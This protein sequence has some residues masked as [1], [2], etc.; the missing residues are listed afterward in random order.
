MC[1]KIAIIIIFL[2]ISV[3]YS[4]AEVTREDIEK[5]I[6][7]GNLKHPYLFFT[8]EDKPA[9]LERIQNDPVSSDI[10]NRLLAEA[11][12][13]LYTPVES[14]LPR[15]LKNPRYDWSGKFLEY[16]RGYFKAAFQLAFV[17][18]MT[19]DEKYA[20][21]SFEFADAMCDEP[22]WV[23]RAHQFPIIYSR[24][25]PMFV[26]DDRVVFNYD[27]YAAHYGS[28]NMSCVYDWLYDALDKRQRDRIRGALLEK[29]ITRVRG[30][31]EYFW[32]ATSYRCNWLHTCCSGLGISSLALLTEDP[33][34]TD[35][36]AES[37]NRIRRAYDEIGID[38][39][40]QEGVNYSIGSQEAAVLFGDPLKRLTGGKYNL[41]DHPR[42]KENPVTF[43]LYTSLPPDKAVN[44]C[45]SPYENIDIRF[46]YIFNKMAA[47]YNSGETAWYAN[48]Y[49]GEG[50]EVYDL[51]WPKININHVIPEQTSI[52]FRT[53]DWVVMRSDF[54]GT[55]SVIVACK[56]GMNDDPHHG[57]LDC[58]QFIV[59]WRGQSFIRDL[60]HGPYDEQYFDDARW[61]YPHASSAGHNVVFVN[62]ELQISAKLKNQP[63][64]EGIGGKVLE[65][66][67]GKNRDYTL[68][69]LA[70]A[71]PKKELKGWRRHITLEK[72]TITVVLDE[73]MSKKGAEIEARFFSECTQNVQEGYVI[74]EGERGNMALIPFVDG[75]FTLRLGKHMDMPVKKE[76]QLNEIPYCGTIVKAE[77]SKTIIATLILPV[78]NDREAIEITRS[79]KRTVDNSGNLSISFEKSGKNY[80][81]KYIN[82]RDGL[83][84]EK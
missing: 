63:W 77:D 40:W 46:P 22:T 45:D 27:I 48:N 65:F 21:K 6:D 31:W 78:D 52:H 64:K 66:R 55:K 17:Y 7:I 50:S 10:M 14:P 67:T 11:N 53:I 69:D 2:V 57:H 41:F 58:G 56:A 37:Y 72:P 32:W 44:F 30:K 20:L 24:I 28:I 12:R 35:V 9:M 51:I 1:K 4:S 16:Y 43:K 13:Y 42:L 79:V 26:P 29:G 36:I 60:G 76:A 75:D 82:S 74:L 54:A 5:A 47:E 39:G 15:Q 83:V 84:L 61:D 68:M 81:Y 23:I 34:L 3:P 62:G 73:V 19:G 33:N 70:N 18:Q 38:G 8:E 59:Y 25:M 71:Y 49:V 80:S